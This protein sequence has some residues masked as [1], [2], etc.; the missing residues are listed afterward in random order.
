MFL[1]TCRSFYVE[2]AKQILQR[3][4]FK[5]S[6]F[7]FIDLVNPSVAQSFTFKSLKP[8]FVRFPVLYAY[9]NMQY[10][11]DDEWREYALLDHES[12][13]LH[14]SDDAEEYW[15]KVFHLKNALGQ[16]LFPNF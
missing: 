5:D 2:L 15:L 16:S 14:P 9:Y 7:N 6:L 3:F 11:V 12:Y 4:D 10:A 1:I 13:D 8:I